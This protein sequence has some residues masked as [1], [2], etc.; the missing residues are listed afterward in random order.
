M[1]FD[2]QICYRRQVIAQLVTNKARAAI[3]IADKVVVVAPFGF[4]FV[5]SIVIVPVSV[6]IVALASFWS[7]PGR[8]SLLGVSAVV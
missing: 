2:R 5:V 8:T 4:A 3:A 6:L 7:A 1:L